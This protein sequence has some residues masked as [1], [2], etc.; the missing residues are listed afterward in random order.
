M[1]QTI[2][3]ND[4]G[5]KEFILEKKDESYLTRESKIQSFTDRLVEQS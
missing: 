4:D 2:Q 3:S 5:A 1:T